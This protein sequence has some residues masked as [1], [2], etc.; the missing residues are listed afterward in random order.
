MGVDQE[1]LDVV[2]DLL[3]N[4]STNDEIV[5]QLLLERGPHVNVKTDSD[6]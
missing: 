2:F 6:I 3:A 1:T 4:G 5:E